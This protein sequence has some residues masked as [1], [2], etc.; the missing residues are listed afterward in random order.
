LQRGKAFSKVDY[1]L[2][3]KDREGLEKRFIDKTI[4]KKI[5]LFQQKGEAHVMYVCKCLIKFFFIKVSS[6]S[7]F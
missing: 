1:V 4:G 2:A 3:K 7:Q 6:P 5:C